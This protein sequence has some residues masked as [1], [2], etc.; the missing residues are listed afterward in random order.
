MSWPR[1]LARV[2]R[3]MITLGYLERIALNPSVVAEW[4]NEA[5]RHLRSATLLANDD[6]RLA[7]AACHDA[8][9]KALTGVLAHRGLRPKGG[10]GAHARIIEWGTVALAADVDADT[11]RRS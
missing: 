9:R 3:E 7:Y 8:I 11:L 4:I 6:P 10:E 1:G 5:S 2:E